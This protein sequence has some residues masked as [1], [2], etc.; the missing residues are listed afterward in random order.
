MRRGEV[1]PAPA[2][3]DLHLSADSP[4]SVDPLDARLA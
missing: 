1:V 2:T 3:I 4:S